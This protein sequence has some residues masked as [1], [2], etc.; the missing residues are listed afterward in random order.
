MAKKKSENTKLDTDMD[1]K[2]LGGLGDDM[3]FGELENID[4]SRKPSGFGV[5]KELSREAGKGFLD[6][7]VKKTAKKSLPEEYQTHYQDALDYADF[8]KSTFDTNKSKVDKSAYRLGKEVKKILPFQLKMLDGFLQKYESE[9]EEMRAQSEEQM[10]DATIQSNLSSIF[11]RQLEVQKAL[12]VKR[13][14]QQDIDRKERL[15]FSKLNMDTLTSIDNNIGSQTAF[16]LQVSKEYYRRSLELQYKSYFVQAD[17]LRTM[18]DYYKGFSIQFD[19]IAKNTGLPEFVKLNNTEHI[20]D[21]VRRQMV[22]STYRTLFTNSDYV[23]KVKKNISGL[24]DSKISAITDKVDGVTDQLSMINMASEGDT[25][26]GLGLLGNVLSGTLGSTL[27]EKV[28]EKISPKIKNRLKDNKAVNTGANY[29][30]MLGNSP[31]T[32]FGL[33]KGKTGK[34][35]DQYADESNPVRFLAS[36]MFGGL[37]ELLGVTDPGAVNYKVQGASA[38]N[39]NKPAIFDNKVHRSITEVIPM[40]LSKILKENT[41]LRMMYSHVNQGKMRGMQIGSQELH[42]DYD[43]RTLTTA[44]KLQSAM[45]SRYLS[46]E[47]SK[48]KIEGVSKSL[49]AD[50]LSRLSQDKGKN[51][52]EISALNSE[53]AKKLLESY[54]SEASKVDAMKFDYQTVIEDA[55]TP[56]KANPTLAKMVSESPE[57]KNVLE[58]LQKSKDTTSVKLIDDRM[59]DSKRQYPIT[60]V[61]QLFLGASKLAGSKALNALNDDAAGIVAKGFTKYITNAGQD[62]NVDNCADGSALRY[63]SSEEFSA[64]KDALSIFVHEVNRVKATND[65]LQESTLAVLFGVVNKSL[66]DNFELDPK[67]FQT[68]HELSPIL[69]ETGRLSI[70]NLVERKLTRTKNVSYVGAEELRSVVKTSSAGIEVLRDSQASQGIIDKLSEKFDQ[71]K[72]GQ[73]DRLNEDLKNANNPVAKGRVLVKYLKQ[74]GSAVKAFAQKQYDETANKLS[75]LSQS[76]QNLANVAAPN[77]VQYF[78]GK[79]SDVIQSLDKTIQAEQA[80]RDAELK[81]L[82]DAK[83]QLSDLV[84]DAKALREIE[85]DI[86]KTTRMFDTQIKTL[87]SLKATFIKQRESLMSLQQTDLSAANIYTRLRSEVQSTIDK[88]RSISE[89]YDSELKANA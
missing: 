21:E 69:G 1:F 20:A 38:L 22:Q 7:L 6:G 73:L 71:F 80:N 25:G 58:I 65:A 36:K 14:A 41:D 51:K 68:L 34:L 61:K 60:G 10:R 50:S 23:N 56:S 49:V 29:L 89:R 17:M 9:N 27:G 48:G 42:Y 24:I 54:L 75:D 2:D 64:V 66:K 35:K 44:S 19:S 84:D 67:V 82:N 37:N 40:Y 53:K 79:L 39:H 59:A 81:K 47:S 70:E 78:T 87:E 15:S 32:L 28:G 18:R 31:S 76:L 62:V 86:Q 77:A 45:Q 11:D 83:A 43:G 74:T 4:G 16:T 12:E 8:A 63:F 3:D 55:L 33:L 5:A 26:G 52:K 46:S 72:T 88:V 13:D 85:A 57:L 30:S